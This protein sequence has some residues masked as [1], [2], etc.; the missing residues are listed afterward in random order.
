[1]KNVKVLINDGPLLTSLR[2]M[3]EPLGLRIDTPEINVRLADDDFSE[4]VMIILDPVLG[5]DGVVHELI[6]T[7]K[8]RSATSRIPILLCSNEANHEVLIR[9]LGMGATDFILLPASPRSVMEAIKR[10]L[11]L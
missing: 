4:T 10:H 1:M 11:H 9:G 8:S 5:A 2:S 7:L 3:L 6:D